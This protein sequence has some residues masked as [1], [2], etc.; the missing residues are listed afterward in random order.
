MSGDIEC[1]QGH[2]LPLA[3]FA[4]FILIVCLLSIPLVAAIAIGKVQVLYGSWYF[5][6]V[7]IRV[8]I[9]YR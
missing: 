4:I 5:M 3:L 9:I 1:Y 8:F 7:G 2:H 6:A